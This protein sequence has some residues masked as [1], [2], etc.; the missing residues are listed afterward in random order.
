MRH[1]IESLAEDGEGAAAGIRFEPLPVDDP[2]RRCP[3]IT[4]ARQLLG[5]EP[6]VTL[7]EGLPRTIEFFRGVVQLRQD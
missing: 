3:D 6:R 4:K 1:G 2:K 5:W 7:E